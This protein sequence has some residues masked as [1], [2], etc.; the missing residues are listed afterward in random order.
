[1]PPIHDFSITTTDGEDLTDQILANP[2][3]TLLMISTKLK[4][5]DK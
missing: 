4:E 2:G 3:Y 5:A 1:M